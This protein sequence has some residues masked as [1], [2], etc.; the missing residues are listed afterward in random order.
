M[1]VISALVEGGFEFDWAFGTSI[2]AL[3][4]T[5]LAQGKVER[6][7][8][9]WSS[10]RPWDIFGLPSALHIGEMVM[11]GKLSLLDASPLERLMRREADLDLL[12]SSA[13]KLGV[14]TT[15]LR[16]LE[17]RL[18]TVDD[19]G[20]PEELIDALMATAAL[21]VAFPPRQ[22]KGEGLWIDGGLVRN[23][24]LR[25]AIERGVDE[26]FMVLLH[27]ETADATP[28]NL[29]QLLSRCLDVALDAS[30]S[31]ELELAWFYNRLISD[32]GAE[33]AAG[34]TVRIEIFQPREPVHCTLLEIDPERSKRLLRMGYEDASTLLAGRL[35]QEAASQVQGIVPGALSPASVVPV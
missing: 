21:P 24:P 25:A 8:E 33:P 3:N 18:I 5:M 12:R 7:M 6:A 20:S 34:H 4:A 30:A 29:W 2:G 31:K 26:I 13:T 27:P 10:L 16:S 11:G 22:L 15:D 14:V 28:A 17:T 1:G 23:T 19:I 35:A 32:R 9:L